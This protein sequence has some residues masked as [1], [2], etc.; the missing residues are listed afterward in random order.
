MIQA[1]RSPAIAQG[2]CVARSRQSSVAAG[3]CGVGTAFRAML[4]AFRNRHSALHQALRMQLCKSFNNKFKVIF[5][6]RS[7]HALSEELLP[8]AA[9]DEQQLLLLAW[10]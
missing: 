8:L 5:P 4:L 10:R 3:K 7:H 1:W 2:Y 6:P 9:Q